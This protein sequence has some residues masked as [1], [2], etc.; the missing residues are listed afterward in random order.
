MDA[1]NFKSADIILSKL[2]KDPL[3]SHARSIN[4]VLPL[5]VEK[6]LPS[7][8]NYL[9]S[10]FGQTTLLR[11]HFRRGTLLKENDLEYAITTAH[12]WP[13]KNELKKKLFS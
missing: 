9:D 6:Q 2:C 11:D 12:L 13:D 4:D 1:E 10:R 5:L 8:G 3:D 7:I